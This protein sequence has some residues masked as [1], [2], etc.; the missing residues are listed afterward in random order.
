M[1]LLSSSA[2]FAAGLL[3]ES[4]AM[5]A[6]NNYISG[7]SKNP[8]N[9]SLTI[10]TKKKGVTPKLSA[11]QAKKEALGTMGQGIVAGLGLVAGLV[12]SAASSMSSGADSLSAENKAETEAKKALHVDAPLLFNQ[13]ALQNAINGVTDAVNGNTV[14]TA[15]VFG[16]LDANLS[17]ISST[18]LAI[19]STLLEIS[20][21]Y[22]EQIE[23]ADDLPYLDSETFYALL[24][25]SGANFHEL[26]T[27]RSDED[28]L[29]DRLSSSG[30]SYSEIKAA[31]TAFRNANIPASTLLKA[32]KSVAGISTPSPVSGTGEVKKPIFDPLAEWATSAKIL[33]DFKM[34]PQ[35]INDLDG[36]PISTLSPAQAQ[37]V[38]HATNARHKTDTNNE[39]FDESMFPSLSLPI[40]PFIGSSD[41][42]NPD[43]TVPSGNP[44]AHKLL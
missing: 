18:L 42:F 43:H 19:S 27:W 11:K 40:L 36:S 39:E 44:F 2:S 8:I 35:T 3:I 37:A 6:V 20:D 17:A 24:E 4:A 33:A 9:P 1:S 25:K 12:G 38:H 28:S 5:V 7:S 29:V 10:P 31:V 30:S 16:R 41:I 21:N 22:S 26:Q 32:N 23:K 15:T 34:E 13:V 14:V